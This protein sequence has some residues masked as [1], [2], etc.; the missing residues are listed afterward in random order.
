MGQPVKKIITQTHP[1]AVK[2]AP[3]NT[4]LVD[5]NSLLFMCFSDDKV[6][7]DGV[8]YGGIYQFL[9]QL[10]LI[11]QRNEFRFVYVFFDDEFSGY[12][13]WKIYP[14]YKQNRDKNYADYEVS[15]YEKLVNEKVRKMQNYYFKDRKPKEKSEWDKFVD[16]NF[17]RERDTLCR[18]FNELYIRWYIDDITEGDDLISYYCANKEDNERI[19]IMSGDMDITQLVSDTICVYNLRLKKMV[20]PNNFKELFGYHHENVVIKKVMCGDVSDNIGHIKLMSE[21]AFDNFM[22][23]YKNRKVTLDEIKDRAKSLVDE[24]VRN[25]K[26]PLQL[27]TNILNGV[28]TKTYDGDFYDINLKLVDLSTPM[29]SDKAKEEMD[30]MMYAPQDPSDRSFSNLYRMILEDGITEWNGDT[31]FASFFNTFKKLEEKEVRFY[32]ESVGKC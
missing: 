7:C 13:R 5:G 24:R 17:T 9:L 16:E 29:V 12:M 25:K 15:D 6:N 27:H 23:E 11:M 31:K 22:P 1:N 18:Y 28:T 26:K 32:E 4:L 2:D 10:K 3:Y 30:A 14:H 20:T 19:C 8:H 21:T